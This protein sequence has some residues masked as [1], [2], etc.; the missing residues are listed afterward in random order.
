M[1]RFERGHHFLKMPDVL[2]VNNQ[3]YGERDAT[4]ADL[5]FTDPRSQFD[6]VRVRACSGD[7]VRRAFARILKAELDMVK[8]SFHKLAQTL[9]RKSD[10][11]CDQVGIQTR[12]ARTYDQ[13][14]QIR[15]RQRLASGEVQM[16]NAERGS[17]AKN[18]QPVG[19]RKLLFA[20]CQLQRIRAIHAMQP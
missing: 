14:G 5:T 9:A 18:A 1:E 15:T 12:L 4:L 17:L 8:S 19:G 13:F 2:P 16:Q 20:R 3:V 10:A 7:P 11:G 6:L